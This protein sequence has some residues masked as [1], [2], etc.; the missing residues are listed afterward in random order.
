MKNFF[1]SLMTFAA[2]ASALVSCSREEVE[3]KD[4]NEFVYRFEIAEGTTKATLDQEGVWWEVEKDNVGVIVDGENIQAD[5]VESDGKK[6][7]SFTRETA[8]DAGTPIYSYYPYS[9]AV[10]SAESA[11]VTIP[12]E[13][14]GA[15]VSAMPM[16]GIPITLESEAGAPSSGKINF[17]NLGAII[18][19]RIYSTNADYANETVESVTFKSDSDAAKASGTATIDLTGVQGGENPS[20]PTIAFGDLPSYRR[21]TVTQSVSVAASKDAATTPMYLV[22][23]PGTFSGTVTVNTNAASYTFKFTNKTLARNTITKFNMNIGSSKAEREAMTKTYEYVS[24]NLTADT[25]L[26]AG[27]ENNKLSVALFPNVSTTSWNSSQTG[28]VNDGQIITE[29]QFG[30]N[31]ALET[32]TTDDPTIVNSEVELIESG[33]AWLVKVKKTG[34]YL[35][36][37]AE[38]YRI[39]FTDDITSAGVF[40]AST[41]SSGKRN[42]N[43]SS[44][45]SAYYVYHAGSANGFT[46]RAVSTSNLRF[47]KLSGSTKSQTL[48]FQNVPENG[49]TWDL[50]SQ[51]DFVEPT[52]VG[53]KTTV[54]YTS[55]NET[56]AQVDHTDGYVTFGTKT[57]TVTITATAAGMDG[58]ASA[59]ASYKI[60]VT[61]SNAPTVTY[62]KASIL[63]AV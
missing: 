56:I 54:V 5:V 12:T 26:I 22:V 48:S 14:E 16:A 60:V 61:N 39:S 34:K 35:V 33:N 18:D 8:I 7:I 31:N 58:Y 2:V 20:V 53:A 29:K 59:S 1:Y 51:G 45:G 63:E 9:E 40:T 24:G 6:V 25:Y 38:E 21:A 10:T 36:A 49:L 62:Y 43:Y 44:E 27:S 50:A 32:I 57:G 19:F 11:R 13:Q 55:S 41:P 37:P 28:A 46:I 47:Y 23:A 15:S 4:N 52:L 42:L 17:L 30:T 3:V